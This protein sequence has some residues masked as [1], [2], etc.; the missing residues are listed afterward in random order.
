VPTFNE[1]NVTPIPGGFVPSA[2]VPAL[3]EIIQLLRLSAG[4]PAKT[5]KALFYEQG[6]VVDTAIT[7]V[8]RV[9]AQAESYSIM[10]IQFSETSGRGRYQM[11]GANPTAAG[12]GMPIISGGTQLTI[13]GVDNINNFKMIAETGQAMQYNALLFKAQAWMTGSYAR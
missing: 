4:D 1:G 3:V 11:T 10:I 7:V 9:Q 6:N 2:Y 5:D 8:A 13:R 12:V